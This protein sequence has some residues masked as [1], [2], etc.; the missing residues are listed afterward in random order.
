MF[1]PFEMFGPTGIYI[2]A[3]TPDAMTFL[4]TC[5]NADKGYL[6]IEKAFSYDVYEKLVTNFAPGTAEAV[7]DTFL[8]MLRERKE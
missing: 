8:T 4:V 6:P 2:K 1:A 7:A 3:N 5:A